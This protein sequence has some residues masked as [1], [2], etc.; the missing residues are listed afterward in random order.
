M[1]LSVLGSFFRLLLPLAPT[2]FGIMA[3]LLTCFLG[4][5]TYRELPAD[6]VLRRQL[7]ELFP[8]EEHVPRTRWVQSYEWC[9]PNAEK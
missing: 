8:E 7:L 6:H 5:W 2:V 9:T 4:C 1:G 3:A